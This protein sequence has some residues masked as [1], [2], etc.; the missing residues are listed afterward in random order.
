[1]S[2]VLGHLTHPPAKVSEAVLLR[3]R[4]DPARGHGD[5]W[6]AAPAE[7]P[8]PVRAEIGHH[9]WLVPHRGV[10]GLGIQCR[11]RIGPF[12]PLGILSS[13]VPAGLETLVPAPLSLDQAIDN[14]VSPIATAIS[15]AVFW[16]CLLYT[17]PSPRDS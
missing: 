3:H 15:D 2:K 10:A 16:A 11:Q 13:P 9:R 12:V 17:S 1:M 4:R 7:S 5:D 8:V 14:F 6:V